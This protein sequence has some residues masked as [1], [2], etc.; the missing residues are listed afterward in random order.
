MRHIDRDFRRNSKYKV[1]GIWWFKRNVE[2]NNDC[3]MFK[4]CYRIGAFSLLVT[5][6]E[7][8]SE[9]LIVIYCAETTKILLFLKDLR[10]C[11]YI[12]EWIDFQIIEFAV[13][14]MKIFTQYIYYAILITFANILISKIYPCIIQFD[15]FRQLT[16]ISNQITLQMVDNC[17]AKYHSSIVCLP[18]FASLILRASILVGLLINLL[19]LLRFRV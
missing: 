17:T 6:L 14:L 2:N 18:N 13:N 1:K 12:R 8:F 5:F 16:L 15:C 4:N 7:I 10:S 9:L 3:W 19:P 11:V